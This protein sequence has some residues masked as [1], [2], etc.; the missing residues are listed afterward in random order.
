M[1]LNSSHLGGKYESNRRR[2]DLLLVI[3]V[4][5]IILVTLVTSRES[6][7]LPV[8]AASVTLQGTSGSAPSLS[9]VVAGT[10]VILTW[11]EVVSVTGYEVHRSTTP[12]FTPISATLQTTLPTGTTTYT[13]TG[14]AGNPAI[15]YF[16]QVR[17]LGTGGSI[18]DSNEVGEIDYPLNNT[19][20]QYSLMALPFATTAITDAASLANYVGDIA[21][22]LAWNPNTQ[23]FR[24]FVPPAT[25]DYFALQPGT[26]F[27]IDLADTGPNL[28]P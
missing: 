5:A 22:V 6:Q 26:P 16:Y 8:S 21:A 7:P 10:D 1:Y 27:V 23:A 12:F 17:T 4:I 15:S 28:W 13:D 3:L 18:A 19:G 24:F 25:G 11:T 14:A 9:I 2:I 20:G